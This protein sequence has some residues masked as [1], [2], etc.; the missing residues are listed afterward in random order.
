MKQLRFNTEVIELPEGWS[1][2]VVTRRPGAVPQDAICSNLPPIEQWPVFLNQL[3]LDPAALP[4][5]AVLK[6]SEHGEVF[7]AQLSVGDGALEVICKQGRV[8]GFSDRLVSALRASR[9]QRNCD[10][11]MMLLEAGIR[12][13]LPLAV[14]KRRRPGPEAWLVTEF[15]PGLVD[16]DEVVLRLLPRMARGQLRRTKDA[17]VKAIV[18]MLEQMAGNGLTHRDLKASNILLENWDGAGGPANVWLV[19]LDG[20]GR[21]RFAYGVRRWEHVIRLAASL[22]SYTAVTRSD[23][24]RFLQAYLTRMGSPR[25]DWKLHFRKL[26]RQARDYVRRAGRRKAHK[27]DGYQGD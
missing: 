24:C 8:R 21:R 6:Y 26:S 23:Y 27:L 4:G 17:I 2:R 15:V 9:E 1:G 13:A 3:T 11:A 7:R 25:T 18:E 10:R 16:L 20:L 5:Y 12:T 22:L 14:V 19:D